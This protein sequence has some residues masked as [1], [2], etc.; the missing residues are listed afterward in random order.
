MSERSPLLLTCVT[1]DRRDSD[2]TRSRK[3]TDNCRWNSTISIGR[4][5][6]YVSVRKRTSLIPPTSVTSDLHRH[7]NRRRSDDRQFVNRCRSSEAPS[8]SR[9][10]CNDPPLNKPIQ[11]VHSVTRPRGMEPP[12]CPPPQALL[13]PP[14]KSTLWAASGYRLRPATR[15]SDSEEPGVT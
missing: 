9:P 5:S 3:I 11:V 8:S 1:A 10:L 2:G 4:Q 6:V 13:L 12:P 15:C 14:F 7:P